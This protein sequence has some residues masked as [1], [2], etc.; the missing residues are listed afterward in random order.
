MAI[1]WVLR[2]GAITSALIGASRPSQIVDCAKAVENIEFSAEELAKI[3]ALTNVADVNLWAKS[4]T[5]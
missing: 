3:D 4:S 2:D 1:A 5:D